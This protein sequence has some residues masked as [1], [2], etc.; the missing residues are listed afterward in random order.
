[1]SPQILGTIPDVQRWWGGQQVWDGRSRT[2]VLRE[3][4][5]TG[6]A[7][8]GTSCCLLPSSKWLMIASRLRNSP[9]VFAIDWRKLL[10]LDRGVSTPQSRS[11][12]PSTVIALP[13]AAPTSAATTDP[14]EAA[15]LRAKYSR[16]RI[17]VI[18][19][20]NAGKT[21]L[22]KRVC[23]TTEEPSIYDKNK[24]LVSYRLIVISHS[25]R[26]FVNSLNQPQR[27]RLSDF[28][29]YLRSDNW[30]WYC[31][32][33]FMTFVVHS[34]SRATRGLFSMTL[35]DS[36][37]GVRRNSRRWWLSFKS[38]QRPRKLMIKFMSSG[39][40]SLMWF[41]WQCAQVL[42][43]SGCITPFAAIGSEVL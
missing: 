35:L 42:L 10:E 15:K 25:H 26:F 18:G 17:L 31:S 36:S 9:K 40:H 13:P 29:T 6:Y 23:N 39:M 22:L 2:E 37:L 38:A 28:S 14:E 41:R 4:Y 33:G 30:F 34:P 24:N 1:M 8:E 21:T 19:R 32:G 20:A 27:C 7:C 43:W 12:S 16:F 11:N 3:S 5:I